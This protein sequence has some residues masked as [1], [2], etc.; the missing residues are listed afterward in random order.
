[1]N[2]EPKLIIDIP[3]R[4]RG[5][6]NGYDFLAF[7]S[8]ETISFRNSVVVLNFKACKW[9]DGNLCAVLGTILEGVRSRNNVIFLRSLAEHILLVFTKNKFLDN[10]GDKPVAQDSLTIPY[11]KFGL[12]DEQKTKDFINDQLFEKPDMPLMS[13]EARKQILI[14]FFEV[15]VNAL[16]HGECENVYVCGQIFPNKNPPEVSLTFSDLG[17][18][19][20]A[21]VN[22]F[23]QD[24]LSGNKTLLWA[25]EDG[26]TTKVGNTGGIGLKLLESLV[27]LNQGSLQ[28]VSGDG[29][30]EVN[31][32]IRKEF[33]MSGYFPGTI[34]TIR[35]RL[36]DSN[37]YR[38]SN[39][40]DINDIF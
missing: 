15:C 21:N 5:N 22:D 20:K 9:F 30:I 12:D 27:L 8:A 6:T 31:R 25:L 4:V 39:E 17:R 7:L 16:T 28:L 38:M 10:F 13:L 40:V 34:V 35:L 24:S 18:T 14:A 37:F 23:L 33:S 19:I 11:N 36:R 29:F 3:E 26:H 1:M 2:T 32:G